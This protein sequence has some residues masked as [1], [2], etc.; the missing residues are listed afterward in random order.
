MA[1]FCAARRGLDLYAAQVAEVSV[2]A[3]HVRVHKVT[4]VVDCGR[5]IVPDSVVAQMQGGAIF[6]LTAALFGNITFKDGRVEQA[7][8]DSYRLLRMNEAP[9]IDTH[10]LDSEETPGGIGEVSTV[11]IAPAVVNAVFA[12]TGKRVR[13]LPIVV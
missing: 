3:D 10:L 4:C 1:T 2:E 11:T 13:R 6:G 8:F 12:A 7:N 5:A 9:L